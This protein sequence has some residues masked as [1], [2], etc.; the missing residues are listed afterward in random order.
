MKIKDFVIKNRRWLNLIVSLFFLSI[1]FSLL[2]FNQLS[3]FFK[4]DITITNLTNLVFTIIAILILRGLRWTLLLRSLGEFD[5]SLISLF[6]FSFMSQFYN[7]FLFFGSGDVIKVISL[8]I[9]EVDKSIQPVVTM[10]IVDRLLDIF[11]IVSGGLVA[12]VLLDLIELRIILY[13]G[14]LGLSFG[15]ILLIIFYS[16][17]Y[18]DKFKSKW[19]IIRD[20]FVL[21]IQKR[22]FIL[23]G[24][25]LTFVVWI[26]EGYKIYQFAQMIALNPIQLKTAILIGLAGWLGTLILI[27]ISGSLGS[28][29]FFLTNLL[30][31]NGIIEKESGLI[32]IVD[33]AFT[34]ITSGIIF[35]LFTILHNL[36]S[37]KTNET[38]STEN[39]IEDLDN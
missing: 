24:L 35:M 37:L 25:L 26:F 17:G 30:K 21:I 11:V 15:T 7:S 13:L 29:E 8:K 20:Q 36:T 22:I 34:I 4:K 9:N 5:I 38:L 19:L 31:E 18:I 10:T 6:Y 3:E 28:K 1:V 12:L 39:N 16:V 23:Q 32:S 33:R 2:D 14:V 27:P